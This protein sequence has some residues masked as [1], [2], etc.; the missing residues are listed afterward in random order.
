MLQVVFLKQSG[1][2]EICL[3][4]ALLEIRLEYSILID[5]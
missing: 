4:K 2:D 5:P 1:W 3:T